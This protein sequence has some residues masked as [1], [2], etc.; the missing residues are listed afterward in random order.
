[1]LKKSP[2]LDLDVRMPSLIPLAIPRPAPAPIADRVTRQ[3]QRNPSNVPNRCRL[4]LEKAM[5]PLRRQ[6]CEE[7]FMTDVLQVREAELFAPGP[8]RFGHSDAVFL[9]ELAI[10]GPGVL[11]RRNAAGHIPPVAVSQ[12]GTSDLLHETGHADDFGTILHVP[13]QS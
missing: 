13:H 8:G 2:T 7:T 9:D 11:A 6:N 4:F 3:F 1:G 10:D 5:L 12:K